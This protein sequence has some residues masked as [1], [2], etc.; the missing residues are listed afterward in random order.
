MKYIKVTYKW[1]S[2]NL[3]IHV[4]T[5][6]Q[7]L[8]TFATEQKINVNLT[9]L[10]GGVLCDGTGCKVQ[11]VREEDLEKA[12]A[13]FKAL[14][15]EH[16][17]SVQKAKILP[18]LGVLY[19]VDCHK[20]D[21]NEDGK[22]LSAITCSHSVLRPQEEIGRLRLKARA[23]TSTRDAK[24][25]PTGHAPSKKT[26]EA[27]SNS[28][29]ASTDGSKGKNGTKKKELNTGIAAMF[30]AQTCKTKQ[31]GPNEKPKAA[32]NSSDKPKT[33][34]GITMF[35]NRQTEK[36]IKPSVSAPKD[37]PSS[38]LSPKDSHG[39][40]V[41]ASC[42][43][44]KLKEKQEGNSNKKGKVSSNVKNSSIK[45]T[46]QKWGGGK[47][48]RVNTDEKLLP[49]KKRKRIVVVSDSEDSSDDDVFGRDG[50]DAPDMPP[51]PEV[52]PHHESD[53]DD[54]IP[55]TPEAELK[56]GRKRVRKMKDKTYVDED[57]YILTCKEY[58]FESCTDSEVEQEK[59]NE[60]KLSKGNCEQF[61]T[62]K[63]E[64][65]KPVSKEPP[66][67]KKASPQKTKQATLMNFFKKSI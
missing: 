11:I 40:E 41:D 16:V 8:Y 12:K 64:S 32:E 29:V 9:Y 54:V 38:G 24:R 65:V 42:A 61:E 45:N 17:Y 1:L 4:N 19:A 66:A 25:W 22:R 18:D 33:S 36:P 58:V 67:K 52:A 23:A 48:K 26:A 31:G 44:E 21:E 50:G 20:R 57:G 3:G 15:S 39:N 6:K 46:E 37:S 14:T 30:A 49:A 62:K 34:S 53:T 47:G 28:E 56:R 60:K 63:S 5:A 10:V 51:L 43:S 55:P 7:L 35:F 59:E 27:H 2:K 13:E